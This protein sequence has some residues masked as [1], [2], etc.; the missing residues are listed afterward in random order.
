VTVA[1]DTKTQFRDTATD[2]AGN[3]S[4]CSVSLKCVE[5]ST[6][7]DTTI[8]SGPTGTTCRPTFRFKSSESNSTL[9]C[10]YDAEPFRACSGAGRDRPPAPLS[11]GSHTFYVRA[12][13]RAKNTAPTPAQRTFTVAG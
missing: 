1:D 9:E 13:D 11:I 4:A 2:A 12:I 7:P 5:D 6:A 8:T 10:R 3:S